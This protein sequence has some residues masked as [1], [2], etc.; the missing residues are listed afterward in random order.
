MYV[1]KTA[2]IG[3]LASAGFSLSVYAGDSDAETFYKETCIVC[4]GEGMHGA[5]KPG[6]KSD[7]EERLGYGIED[8]YLNAIEG[9]GNAM[10]ARG[11]CTD[12][13]DEQIES[14]VD[15]MVKD[16]K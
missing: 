10:P 16:L 8:V 13:S 1:I 4:H 14:I 11:M 12:C 6:I 9:M 15:F 3:V 5:P 7:W 2:I